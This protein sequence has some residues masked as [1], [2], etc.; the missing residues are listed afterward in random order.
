MSFKKAL[1]GIGIAAGGL[2]AAIGTIV[3]LLE[4]LMAAAAVILALV[5]I[6]FDL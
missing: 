2:L 4:F 5:G 3:A 1:K 6:A